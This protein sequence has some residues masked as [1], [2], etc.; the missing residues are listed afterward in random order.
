MTT[1][2]GTQAPQASSK[3]TRGGH[4]SE[5]SP[6]IH[7]FPIVA[8]VLVIVS[9]A[10]VLLHLHLVLVSRGCLV[11]SDALAL[12]VT[13]RDVLSG[14]MTYDSRQASASSD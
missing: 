9:A 13:R 4:K 14:Q 3:D 8:L 11:L 2:S 12:A 7:I 5:A 6:L 1:F 10:P